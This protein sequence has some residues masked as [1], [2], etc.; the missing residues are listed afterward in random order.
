[1]V[2]Q[3]SI[4][5]SVIY[6]I[7]LCALAFGY[8]LAKRKSNLVN[9][10]VSD[11]TI[12]IPFRNEE[13]NLSLLLKDLKIQNYSNHQVQIICVDDHSDDHSIQVIEGFKNDIPIRLLKLEEKEYG[14]KHALIKAWQHIETDWCIQLDADVRLSE[15]WFQRIIQQL[16]HTTDLFILPIICIPNS[17]VQRLFC[18][19]FLSIHTITFSMAAYRSPIMANG[20][21]LIYKKKWAEGLAQ[22]TEWKRT[23]S[24]DDMA[25]LHRVIDKK[26][27]INYS[28]SP[29]LLATTA[30]PRNVSDFLS[31]RKR[32]ISKTGKGYTSFSLIL[33]GFFILVNITLLVLLIWALIHSYYLGALKILFGSKFVFDLLFIL[34]AIVHFRKTNWI[35][36]YPILAIVYPFYVLLMLIKGFSG[37]T[38]W[39]GRTINAS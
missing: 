9:K 26:G 10:T 31:Q 16:D 18:L 37:T 19:E 12:V 24:G 21:H 20:A 30:A 3:F 34:P 2:Y 25:I 6:G 23:S 32:W 13:I 27:I 33:G 7:I 1:M 11:F 14:K 8:L 36:L 39:K 5:V 17:W 22:T 38:E 29:Q 15:R 28:L 35:I 4:L